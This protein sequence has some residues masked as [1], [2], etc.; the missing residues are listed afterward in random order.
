MVRIPAALVALASASLACAGGAFTPMQ[1]DGRAGSVGA[2]SQWQI[3]SSAKAQEGGAQISSAG[4]SARDWYP[5][6]GRA[7]VM[8][9]LP[10]EGH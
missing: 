5:V 3:Q 1:L 7:T 4:Y 6:T 8:P 2:I 10:E 9:G